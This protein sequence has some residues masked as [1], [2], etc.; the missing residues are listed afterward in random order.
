MGWLARPARVLGG[1]ARALV[2]TRLQEKEKPES[3]EKVDGGRLAGRP[4]TTWCQTDLSKSVEVPSTPI[5]TPPHG[6]SQH[7]TLYL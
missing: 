6:E 3:V 5:N 2:A 1:L 4:T 7:T